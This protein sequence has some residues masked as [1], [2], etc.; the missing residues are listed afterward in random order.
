MHVNNKSLNSMKVR[1]IMNKSVVKIQY[2]TSIL[3]ANRIMLEKNSKILLVYKKNKLRGLVTQ[4]DIAKVMK[5]FSTDVSIESIDLDQVRNTMTKN[6]ITVNR[7]GSVEK[8]HELMIKNNIGST[9][10]MEN[11]LPYGIV[12]RRDFVSNMVKDYEA[13]KHL[14]VDQILS[15]PV[16]SIDPNLSVFEANRIMQMLES[17]FKKMPVKVNNKM[18]GIITQTD[19]CGGMYYFISETL[20]K[21]EKKKIKEINVS[22]MKLEPSDDF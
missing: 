1:N 22:R 17:N 21:I 15:T 7:G 9:I 20:N 18:K 3:E 4:N 12:T 16:A 8:A 14:K 6:V 19:V 10:E 11:D 13:L 5:V 2:D